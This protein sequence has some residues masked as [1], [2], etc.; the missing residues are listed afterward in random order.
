MFIINTFLK[1]IGIRYRIY[2]LSFS[3]ET[4]KFKYINWVHPEMGKRYISEIKY[5]YNLSKINKGEN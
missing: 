5:K 4:T 3:Q 1:F 2:K